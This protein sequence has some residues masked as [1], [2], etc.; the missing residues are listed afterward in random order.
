MDAKNKSIVGHNASFLVAVALCTA[1][2]DTQATVLLFDQSRDAATHTIVVPTTSGASVEQDYG[3]RV[4]GA[5]QDVLGGQFT[6]GNE[7]E[8]FTPNVLVDYFAGSSA[9]AMSLWEDSYG[10]LTNVMFGHQ[11]TNTLNVQ[12]TADVGFDVLLYGFDLAG[13][14]NADYTIS[15]VRVLD[16]G[17]ELFAQNNVLVEGNF[18]G[19]RH[20]SFDFATPLSSSQLLIEIDYSNL[21]DS[22]QDNIGIDNV[23][24]GQNPPPT[25]VAAPPT[26]L[27]LGLGLGAVFV[28]RRCLVSFPVRPLSK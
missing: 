7:G 25:V 4:T 3:D 21:A 27:L 8:G 16:S 2:V 11:N 24:F 18:T 28:R 26:L 14:L 13:W 1:A 9:T 22:Q 15:A 5:V 17:M 12:L 6:Y 23:R 10:N 20:T 19:P